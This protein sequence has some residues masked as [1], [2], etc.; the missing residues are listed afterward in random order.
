M[1][2]TLDD[3]W[4]FNIVALVVY[5][6]LFVYLVWKRRWNDSLEQRLILFCGLALVSVAAYVVSL[7]DWIPPVREVF[8]RLHVYAQAA[9]PLFFYAVARAFTHSERQLRIFV[10]GVLLVLGLVAV[11]VLQIWI[12]VGGLIE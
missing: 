11:D 7:I 6:A 2:L 8:L 12:N 3:L 4:L 9:L 10:P 1:A 5:L